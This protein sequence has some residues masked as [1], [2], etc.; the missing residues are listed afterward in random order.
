M[1]VDYHALLVSHFAMA[2][3]HAYFCDAFRQQAIFH[4]SDMA[5]INAG[6]DTS[7][8]IYISRGI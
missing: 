2:A 4:R 7:A 3:S 5:M 1:L 6:I 8:L